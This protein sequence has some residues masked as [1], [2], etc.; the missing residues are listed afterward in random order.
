MALSVEGLPKHWQRV[1][2]YRQ[3]AQWLC[4]VCDGDGHSG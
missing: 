4:V 1:V 3:K 2:V